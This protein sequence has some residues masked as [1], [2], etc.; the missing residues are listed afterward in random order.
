MLVHHGES[1]S[2]QADRH[3]AWSLAGIAGGLNAA[4]FYAVGLYSSNMTGNVSA[5]ADHGALGDFGPG[6]LFLAIVLTFIGGA[7]VSTLLINAGRRRARAGIYAFSILAEAVLLAAL[8]AVDLWLGVGR[9]A[10]LVFGLSFLM[11]LQNAVV[12]RLSNARV[13]TTHVT[14]MVTDIGIELGNLADNAWH[15]GRQHVSDFNREKLVLHGQTVL[16]FLGGG[17][18]GVLGYRAMGGWLL[19]IGAGLLLALAIPALLATRRHAVS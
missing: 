13:R 10:L 1:R 16:S 6:L 11:G 19:F 17:V 15:R 9:G 14:G 12:T 7:I 5:L 4:G 18:L 3:L 2:L 8:A